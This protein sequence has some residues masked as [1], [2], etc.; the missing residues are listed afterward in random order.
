MKTPHLI[1]VMIIMMLFGSSY[2]VSKLV[3]NNS[4][5]PILLGSLRNLIFFLALLPFIKFR[6]PERKY[7]LP[8]IGFS[9]SFGTGV[10]MFMN[11]ALNTSKVVSPI[12]IASQLSVP[13]AI[14]CSSFFIKEKINTRKWLL[15][16]TSFIGII[17][18]GFDPKLFNELNAFILTAIMA[19]FYGLTQVFS[20]HLKDLDHKFST[21]FMG[22][23][24][25]ISLFL[26]SIFFEG[27]TL[28]HIANIKFDTWLL[29][30]HSAILVT[31]LGHMSLFYLYKFYPLGK[32]MPFYSLFPIFGIALTFIIFLEVP[33]LYEIIGGIIVIGSIYLIHLDNN[34][35]N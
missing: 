8:L 1:L 19:F 18:V 25:F 22:L 16:F 12:I 24:G 15:I 29:I 9:F 13:F 27:N 10:F 20:R 5:P 23:V 11:L 34:K 2:P 17:F 14:I 4:V 3:L 33:S 28:H 35:S 30:F 6:V 7:F 31:L 26:I 21:A 32:V